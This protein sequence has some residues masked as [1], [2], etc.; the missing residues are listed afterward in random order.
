MEPAVACLGWQ[1]MTLLCR[2]ASDT[3]DCKAPRPPHRLG[4]A[5]TAEVPLN[6]HL[7]G[8]RASLTPCGAS[9]HQPLAFKSPPEGWVQL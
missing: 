1:S 4:S 9:C 8:C 2:S 3:S 7:W 5:D 6:P